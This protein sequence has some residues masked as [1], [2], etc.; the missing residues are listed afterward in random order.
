MNFKRAELRVKKKGLWLQLKI[1]SASKSNQKSAPYKI[2]WSKHANERKS[3]CQKKII[4]VMMSIVSCS[5][6]SINL[7][8]L[9]V[10]CIYT[11]FEISFFKYTVSILQLR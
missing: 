3:K 1:L 2:V 11:R 4:E 9:T 10:E 8:L 6:K 7:E 5:Y